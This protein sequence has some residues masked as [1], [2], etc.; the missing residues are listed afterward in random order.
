MNKKSKNLLNKIDKKYINIGLIILLVIL[1]LLIIFRTYASPSRRITKNLVG[2]I[3]RL[4][5]EAYGD[6]IFDAS[7]V[8]LTPILDNELELKEN[9]IIKINFQVG[10][11]KENNTDNIV[12]DIALV[13][14]EVDCELLSNE[15]KWLLKKN[16]EI[17]T[18]GSLDY[19]FDTIKNGRLV[20]T[21]IQQD[22]V[23]YNEDKTKYDK[24]EF[25]MWLSD[26]CQEDDLEKCLNQKDQSYLMQKQLKGKIEVELYTENKKELI[27]TPSEELDTSTCIRREGK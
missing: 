21:E 27:R 16:E 12:Y 25:Y 22:L 11:S 26:S 4:D 3:I 7:N 6:I 8:E 5:E 13:D 18:T 2:Q 23:K 14:L 24:Y 1:I 15:V 19:K 20:L 9:N 17:L 10:G